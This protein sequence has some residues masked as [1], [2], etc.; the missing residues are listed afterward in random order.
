M[1]ARMQIFHRIL[2][3]FGLA[4]TTI[5]GSI[6]FGSIVFGAPYAAHASDYLSMLGDVPLAEGLVELPEAGVVF[7]KP[8][9]RIVQMTATHN[10]HITQE[11]L[12]AFYARSLPNLGWRARD[13]DQAQANGI[14]TFARQ[15][16][17]LRLTFSADLV[18]FDLTPISNP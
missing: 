11:N 17:I 9:G 14:L 6:A 8:Q 4:F 10:R 7:D 15:G 16:E 18:I 2:I 1:K 12:I 5:F 13:A 3:G